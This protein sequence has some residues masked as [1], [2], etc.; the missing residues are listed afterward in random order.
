MS[1]GIVFETAP[2]LRLLIL[3]WILC[4]RAYAH[5]WQCETGALLR[6]RDH[7]W[8][9]HVIIHA[10]ALSKEEEEGISVSQIGGVYLPGGECQ[11]F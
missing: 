9:L 2:L 10:I 3:I 6:A 5:N 8:R 1:S 7:Q 4:R 11:F